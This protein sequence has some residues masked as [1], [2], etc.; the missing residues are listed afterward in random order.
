MGFKKAV[1]YG[2]GNIGR[3]FIGQ[4]LYESGYEVCFIDVNQKLIKQ[5]NTEKEYP[6][7]LLDDDGY[8]ETL[9]RNVRA[10]DGND[11]DAVAQ[12][13]AEADICATAVGVNVLKFTAEPFRQGIIRRFAAV[14][15][16]IL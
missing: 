12:A 15:C 5:L 2:A 14:A 13:I 6:V 10:V 4:L 16:P 8:E 7:R 11:I 3:G 9:V 1:M